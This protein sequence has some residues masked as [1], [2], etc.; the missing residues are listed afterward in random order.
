MPVLSQL[1]DG[2]LAVVKTPHFYYSGPSPGILGHITL[3]SHFSSNCQCQFSLFIHV[4]DV[5]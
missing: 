2:V 4:H 1:L 5:H 3:F